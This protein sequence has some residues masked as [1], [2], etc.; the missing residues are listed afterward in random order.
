[1]SNLCACL[2]LRAFFV[3]TGFARSARS[4]CHSGRFSAAFGLRPI[5]FSAAFGL[6]PDKKRGGIPRLFSQPSR[7]SRQA[8][9]AQQAGA[10]TENQTENRKPKTETSPAGGQN[11]PAGAKT[12]RGRIISRLA[13]KSF[14]R[15][16]KI[17]GDLNTKQAG[18]QLPARGL[19]RGAQARRVVGAPR[20]PHRG[21]KHARRGAQRP[22]RHM[23]RREG[24]RRQERRGAR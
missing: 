12:R 16:R 23:A 6:S 13:P 7:H 18:A 11:S 8:Q 9:Q 24:S 21:Q 5:K 4:R 3:P 14:S 19:S 2:V 1:M 10:R 22:R 17:T 20:E 15:G